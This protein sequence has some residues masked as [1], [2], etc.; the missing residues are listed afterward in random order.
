MVTLF[1][2]KQF[3]KN[4]LSS[5]ILGRKENL[6]DI[7]FQQREVKQSGQPAAGG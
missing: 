3:Q 6:G 4:I 2:K 7:F 5:K 1:G